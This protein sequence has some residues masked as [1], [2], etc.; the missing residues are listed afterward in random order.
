MRA[1]IK[2]ILNE[3]N[4]YN[5]FTIHYVG[6]LSERAYKK[7]IIGDEKGFINEI[8]EN[9]IRK[10]Q[11]EIQDYADKIGPIEGKFIDKQNQEKTAKISINIGKHFAERV[12]RDEDYSGDDRFTKVDKKEGVDVVVANIDKI[13]RSIMTMNLKRND[14]IKLKSQRGGITYEV[15]I[16]ILDKETGKPP[17][18]SISLFNQIKGKDVSFRKPVRHELKV[19]NPYF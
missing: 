8:S 15:L 17:K 12:L 2:K 16:D 11:K 3:H 6:K 5:D 10:T 1:L 4:Y 9:Q 7:F 13:V 14:V 19:I 18:Y